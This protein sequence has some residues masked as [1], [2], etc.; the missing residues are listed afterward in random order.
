[1]KAFLI[2]I[3]IALNIVLPINAQHL[4][5]GPNKAIWNSFE[6]NSFSIRY[7]SNWST[8]TIGETDTIYYFK[9]PNESFWD[10]FT[11]NLNILSQ[12]LEGE[13]IDLNRYTEIT[14]AQIPALI[15]N[16][17]IHFSNDIKTETGIYHKIVYSGE[18][19]GWNLK[20]EAYYWIKED[21][22][23]LATFA[24]LPKYWRRYRKTAEKMLDSIRIK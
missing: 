16:G 11:T 17:K 9:A 15:G 12:D 6:T 8:N 22:A 14:E 13:N 21:K 4:D 10:G 24:T 1:M 18:L 5:R 20:W 2:S 19:S 23:I 3:F 7:P